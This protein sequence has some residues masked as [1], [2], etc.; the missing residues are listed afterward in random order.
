MAVHI[1]MIGVTFLSH[2][3]IS[4]FFQ[5]QNFAIVGRADNDFAEFF[6][7]DQTAALPIYFIVY[8]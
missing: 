6:R 7:G 4:Y 8:W 3:D 1:T 2:L 5:L